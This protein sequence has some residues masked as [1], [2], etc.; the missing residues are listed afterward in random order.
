MRIIS[1]SLLL[2]SLMVSGCV[3]RSNQT[4]AGPE[5][6]VMS[7]KIGKEKELRRVVIKLD[8]AAAPLTSANF[9]ALARDGYYDG[10]RF[11]RVFPDLL[12]QS[13]DPYSRRGDSD[14]SGTGGPGYTVPAEIR[15]SHIRGAVAASRLPDGVNPTRASSGS[16]FYICL[17]PMPQLDGDYTVFG[18]VTE[19][20]ETLDEISKMSTNS[21]D[22]PLEKIVIR[23]I[24]MSP[25]VAV[26]VA[27]AV[28]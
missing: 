16:Q 13:G 1:V 14:R 15:L 9:A 27:T 3:T 20:M 28:N 22:F 5:V 7:I 4:Y 17:T 25:E 21:N 2:L 11:H 23:S 12:V 24:T 26:P 8:E 19:G 10:M 6:A 18:R